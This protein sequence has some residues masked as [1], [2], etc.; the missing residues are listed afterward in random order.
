MDLDDPNCP[1]HAVD[2]RH[3]LPN[4]VLASL[5]LTATFDSHLNRDQTYTGAQVAAMLRDGEG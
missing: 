5:S 4:G 3:P 1:L 2:S